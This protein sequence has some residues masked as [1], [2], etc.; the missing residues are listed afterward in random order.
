VLARAE[1]ISFGSIA[2][3]WATTISGGMTVGLNVAGAVDVEKEKA[4][5]TKEIAETERYLATLDVKLKNKE[6]MSKAPA[7]V[8]D[9]MHAKRDAAEAKLEA[10]KDRLSGFTKH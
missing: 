10:L 9:D 1:T 6:F 8:T 7:K 2:D 3:G 4:K 5:L